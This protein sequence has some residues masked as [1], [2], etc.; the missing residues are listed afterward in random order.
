[1]LSQVRSAQ[2]E[3]MQSKRKKNFHYSSQE[4]TGKEDGIQYHS[5]HNLFLHDTH[6]LGRKQSVRRV[7]SPLKLE[8][9]VQAT[10]TRVKDDSK[11][12]NVQVVIRTTLD[13]TLK[14][15]HCE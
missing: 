11:K 7:N 10:C 15:E 3:N 1:M 14:V 2:F 6:G 5:M 13:T 4:L 12:G 9:K 8:T